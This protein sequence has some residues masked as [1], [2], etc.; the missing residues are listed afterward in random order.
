MVPYQ[1]HWLATYIR[2]GLLDNTCMDVGYIA[3]IILQKIGQ[4]NALKK[5]PYPPNP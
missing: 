4:K 5:K 2:I 1:Q 3:I